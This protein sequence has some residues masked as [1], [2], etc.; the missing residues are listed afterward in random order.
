MPTIHR[1]RG[2]R[3]GFRAGDSS[4]P[5]HVHVKGNGGAAKV[6]LLPI[7]LVES[8]GYNRRQIAEIKEIVRREQGNFVE[9]WVKFFS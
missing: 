7:E 6:W 2:Y 8:R 4:E 9:A 5:P 1:E 3:F